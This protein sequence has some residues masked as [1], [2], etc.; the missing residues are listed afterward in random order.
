[1]FYP[2]H[3][4][5]NF[6]PIYFQFIQACWN[7]SCL[8]HIPEGSG[9]FSGAISPVTLRMKAGWLCKLQAFMWNLAWNQSNKIRRA[10]GLHNVLQSVKI[11]QR[12]PYNHWILYSFSRF[13]GAHTINQFFWLLRHPWTLA[14]N[15]KLRCQS[16]WV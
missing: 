11:F 13:L 8:Q 5:I 16:K 6:I 10:K 3:G 14:S 12:H 7:G 9:D 1:M 2:A 15:K 4:E